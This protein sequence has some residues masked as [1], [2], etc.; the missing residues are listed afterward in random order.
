M[1]K[2]FVRGKT[3]TS[4]NS[5]KKCAADNAAINNGGKHGDAG[6]VLKRLAIYLKPQLGLIILSVILSAAITVF[7]LYIPVLIGRAVWLYLSRPRRS[8]SGW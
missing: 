3:D 5:G 6:S 8:A 4:L 7:Q 1:R 2:I